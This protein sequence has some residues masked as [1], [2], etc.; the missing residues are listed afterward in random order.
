[1]TPRGRVQLPGLSALRAMPR[2]RGAT[3]N[4]TADAGNRKP[5][6]AW[7]VKTRPIAARVWRC[8]WQPP[9]RCGQSRSAACWNRA[10]TGS[11]LRTCS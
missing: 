9:I 7:M 11:R 5:R 6:H 1:M 3:G 4:K 10:N 8:T 2:I